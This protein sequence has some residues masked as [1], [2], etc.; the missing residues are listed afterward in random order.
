[1]KTNARMKI[2]N[3]DENEANQSLFARAGHRSAH[4][5]SKTTPFADISYGTQIDYSYYEKS[6]ND[7]RNKIIGLLNSHIIKLV[8]NPNTY[9]IH[10]KEDG[11]EKVHYYI[12]SPVNPPSKN[13]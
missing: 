11:D 3:H 1:M 2:R 6:I 7:W 4:P 8:N 12:F 5:F 10:M 9:L 13:S